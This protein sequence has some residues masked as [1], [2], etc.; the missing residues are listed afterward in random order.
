MREKSASEVEVRAVKIVNTRDVD[1]VVRDCYGNEHVLF[2]MKEKE[3][4]V[5]A[6]KGTKNDPK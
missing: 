4:M 2:P 5:L 3:V 1:L 6:E